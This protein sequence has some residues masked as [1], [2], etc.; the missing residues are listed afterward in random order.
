MDQGFKFQ[1]CVNKYIEEH[2]CGPGGVPLPQPDESP[3]IPP[4]DKNAVARTALVAAVLGT[5]VAA[6]YILAD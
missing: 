5:L 4:P 3:A 1:N 2:G 6:A